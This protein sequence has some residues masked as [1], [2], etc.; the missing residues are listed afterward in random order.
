MTS[1]SPSPAP[2]DDDGEASEELDVV[3]NNNN[4]TGFDDSDFDYRIKNHDDIPAMNDSHLGL[5]LGYLPPDQR[6][7]MPVELIAQLAADAEIEDDTEAAEALRANAN[8]K[9]RKMG[10]VARSLNAQSVRRFVK[11]A[12]LRGKMGNRKGKPP[13]IPPG[14]TAVEEPD[15]N[16]FVVT[17]EAEEEVS[18][19]EGDDMSESS[20]AASVPGMAHD[21]QHSHGSTGAAAVAASQHIVP[22]Q[23]NAYTIDM[24]NPNPI[25]PV[26]LTDAALLKTKHLRH[27]SVIDE[28]KDIPA[29]VVAATMEAGRKCK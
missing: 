17:E 15:S 8:V 21:D 1:R 19:Q 18:S 4:N 27:S 28:A 16:I 7:G 3:N 6:P 29:D 26:T 10:K 14:R 13:R 5:E 23:H 25:G 20:V 11:F 22:D 24:Q 9:V 12:T 2:D